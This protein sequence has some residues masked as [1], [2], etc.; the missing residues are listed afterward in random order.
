MEVIFPNELL[1]SL[2]ED[3]EGFHQKVLH[4]RLCKLYEMG[5]ISGDSGAEILGCDPWDF[6]RLLSKND[7]TVP[8][9]EDLTRNGN[10]HNG[11][12]KHI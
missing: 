3:P 1:T 6:Y 11:N 4:Y 5:E 12:G 7:F 8:E 9:G 2:Q 10:H